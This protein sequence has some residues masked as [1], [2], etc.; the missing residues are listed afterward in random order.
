VFR[1]G[2]LKL[3][4]IRTADY[5]YIGQASFNVTG[6]PPAP[7]ALTN[8]ET[9]NDWHFVG[10][11]GVI[12]WDDTGVIHAIAVDPNTQT[13]LWKGKDSGVFRSTD[14]GETFAQSGTFVNVRGIFIDP[15][16]TVNVYVG[17]ETGLHRSKDAG[18]VWKQIQTGLEGNTTINTLGL[19]PGGLGTRRIFSGTTNGVFMGRTSLD[20]D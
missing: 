7:F 17:T 20:L 12:H 2:Y 19:T 11:G 9:V 1:S 8:P 10:A 18:G 6:G 3:S 13:T 14:D 5:L 16:N 4:N 15:I